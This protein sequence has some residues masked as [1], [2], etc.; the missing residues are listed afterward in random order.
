VGLAQIPVWDIDAS[1]NEIQWARDAGLRGI[2]FPAP[3]TW[4]PEYSKPVWEPFWSAAEDLGMPLV[5]HFGSGSDADYTGTVGMAIQTYESTALFGRRLVPWMI[6]SGVFERHP[7]LKL[8]ITEIP[9][10]WWPDVTSELDSVFRAMTDS[11]GRGAGGVRPVAVRDDPAALTSTCPRFPSEYFS[12][13]VFVGASFLNQREA[14]AAYDGGYFENYL[15]GSDYPHPEGTF[16]YPEAWDETPMTRLAQRFAFSGIPE[17][18]TKRMLGENAIDVYGL[19]AEALSVIA[20]RINAPSAT[21]VS[22]PLRDLPMDSKSFAF[23]QNS[24][25]D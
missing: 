22:E 20:Q 12:S 10:I 11:H 15:W 24:T 3:Q 13:N 6:F 8:V 21:D 23:R 4:I 18:A 17:K 2:N 25:F 9:G 7:A 1:I 19:D 16:Y 5:T 14:K